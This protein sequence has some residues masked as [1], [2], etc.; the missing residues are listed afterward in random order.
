MNTPTD[1]EIVKH[2]TEKRNIGSPWTDEVREA[3]RLAREGLPVKDE[4]HQ[5]Y[6]MAGRASSMA[7]SI[8]IIRNFLAARDAERDAE[9]DELRKALN[10][11]ATAPHSGWTIAQGVAR[12]VL[13]K[14]AAALSDLAALDGEII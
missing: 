7:Q 8:A 14:R 2:L 10:Y 4:A 11:C 5:I 9:M 1:D 3:L 13:A 12:A 6:E